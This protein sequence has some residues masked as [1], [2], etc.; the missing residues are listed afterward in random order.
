[1]VVDNF[2]FMNAYGHPTDGHIYAEGWRFYFRFRGR[3]FKIVAEEIKK[4][5]GFIYEA[6]SEQDKVVF[7]AYFMNKENIDMAEIIGL[8]AT[9]FDFKKV[10]WE[11]FNNIRASLPIT[12]GHCIICN[13]NPET[14]E[15][16]GLYCPRCEAIVTEM[17][18]S[19]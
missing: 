12:P 14:V 3:Q 19:R 1:M 7:M 5:P 16:D 15:F 6:I 18:I 13:E 8:T 2:E 10:M 17:F 11:D 4:E 9:I